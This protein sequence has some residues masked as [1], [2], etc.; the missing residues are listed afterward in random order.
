MANIALLNR[1]NLK[2][3]YC[4]ANEYTSDKSQDIDATTFN[5][6]LDFSAPDREVGLI[7]GEPLLHP[8]LDTF[9][10]ILAYDMRFMRAT[11]FTNGIYIDKHLPSLINPKFIIMSQ[12]K[13]AYYMK[14]KNYVE[15]LSKVVFDKLKMN[16]KT[17]NL[18]LKEALNFDFE[19][20]DAALNEGFSLKENIQYY[21][22]WISGRMVE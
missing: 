16:I 18:K 15:E 10:D 7:G 6:M 11:I 19:D 20:F 4:F 9:L 14:Q 21:D 17:N 5:K 8:N 12:Y 22:N 1:C 13:S 3:P 2:C